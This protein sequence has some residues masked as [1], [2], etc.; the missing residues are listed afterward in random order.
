MVRKSPC[1]VV[2]ANGDFPRHEKAIAHLKNAQVLYCC[3]GAI[4]QLAEWAAENVPLLS[5]KRFF[6]V[7]DG[8][9]LKNDQI[10]TLKA[11]FAQ[12]QCEMVSHFESEQDYNDLTKNIRYAAARGER[13]LV[14]L[15]ATG[16]REDHTLGNISLLATY[17][18]MGLQVK[19]VTDYGTFQM[20]DKDACFESFPRQQV[21]IFSLQPST[22]ISAKGLQYPIDKLQL[23]YWWQGTL[24]AALTDCFSIHF[25][26]PGE[27]LVF[28]TH[29]AKDEKPVD[30]DSDK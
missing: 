9:S 25:D 17:H 12:W 15:G 3:D 30:K 27:L 10:E 26:T 4:M 23:S 11:K 2:L 14:I 19:M 29:E 7:G 22:R 13:E 8:D 18:Q 28:Q 24:N 1:N 20:V 16:Q 5:G 21:S 6:V